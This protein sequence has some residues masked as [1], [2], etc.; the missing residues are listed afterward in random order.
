ML[1][2]PM[3]S[4]SATD[5]LCREVAKK[6]HGVCFA[7]VSRGKD[8]LCMWLQLLK[9]FHRIIPVHF[10][11]MPD[12]R[13]SSEYLDYLEGAFGA[14]ILRMMGEDLKMSLVRHIYQESPWECDV[15]DA[16][17]EDRDYTK[18]DLLDYLRMKFNLPRAW[19]AVGISQ[20][21]SIDRLIY[22]RK[23]GGKN[24]KNRTFY[25][26]YDWPR[27]E[28]LNAISDAGLWLAPEYKYSNRSMGGVPS[29]T[30]NKVMMEH[31]PEDWEKT[32]AWWPLA[33]VKNVREEMI[34]ANYPKWME[35][36]AAKRVKT[37][38]ELVAAEKRRD[39]DE[40]V[41][42]EE[43]PVVEPLSGNAAA[44]EAIAAAEAEA[45]A[46]D[47]GPSVY[48]ANDEELEEDE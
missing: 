10:A 48:V 44:E 27:E 24:L 11:T 36:E 34:D 1:S 3:Y 47:R 8:S 28:L 17:F 18:L 9:F 35:Q 38:A 26:C 21:D 19:C 20:N 25:P 6:S 2:L 39:E 14:K 23:N 5:A 12:C 37:E 32:K 41:A 45:E 31:F 13:Y 42:E 16:V 15:I 30:Y 22:C 43:E 46:E 33:E 4:T 7:F 40:D 29:A